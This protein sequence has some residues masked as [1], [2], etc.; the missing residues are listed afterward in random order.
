MVEPAIPTAKVAP[1]TVR[2]TIGLSA[3]L[4]LLPESWGVSCLIGPK[5]CLLNRSYPSEE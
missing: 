1:K 5:R 3:P 2:Q 4:A